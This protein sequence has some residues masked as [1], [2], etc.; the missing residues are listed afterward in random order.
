MNDCIFCK[1]AKKEI[2]AAIVHETDKVLA[3]NDVN[4]KAPVHILIIPKEHYGRVEQ[5]TDRDTAAE[6]L[7]TIRELVNKHNLKNGYRLVSNN[8]PD[9]HQEVMHLHL[10][11]LGGKDLGASE[12]MRK[13]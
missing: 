2:P 12:I 6:L 13:H 10:H 7:L 5:V 11:L 1:I 3:F 8:G 9:G 4:P